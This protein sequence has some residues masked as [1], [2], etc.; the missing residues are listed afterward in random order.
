VKTQVKAALGHDTLNWRMLNVCPP[1]FYKLED[2]PDLEF[3]YLFSVDGNNSLKR[4][5]AAMHNLTERL[6]SR[7]F[8][9]DRWLTAK[10]VNRFADEVK[11]KPVSC[12]L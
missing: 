6:D 5:G 7:T 9:S 3:S 12:V 4:M 8:L 2:E 10:E 11:R 1:C